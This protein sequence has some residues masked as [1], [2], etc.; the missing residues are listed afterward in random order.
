VPVVRSGIVQSDAV[1]GEDTFV[2]PLRP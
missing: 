1:A 2:S